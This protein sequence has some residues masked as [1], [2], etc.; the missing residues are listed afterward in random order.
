M[1]LSIAPT[2]SIVRRVRGRCKKGEGWVHC[3]EEHQQCPEHPPHDDDG[4]GRPLAPSPAACSTS[5]QH[6]PLSLAS[7]I[8]YPPNYTGGRDLSR[9]ILQLLLVM[10]V[11]VVVVVWIIQLN[12]YP[13]PLLFSQ[14]CIL[15]LQPTDFCIHKYPGQSGTLAL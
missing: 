1:H 14:T 5:S 2:L 11:V 6:K 9:Y 4:G 7:C 15:T 10:I 8:K 13:S 3:P 12:A